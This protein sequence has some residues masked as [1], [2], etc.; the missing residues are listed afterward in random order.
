[1]HSDS[2]NQVDKVSHSVGV[3]L[4]FRLCHCLLL[5]FI[6]KVAMVA[7][8]EVLHGPKNT[9]FQPRQTDLV[10]ATADRLK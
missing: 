4:Y 9:D 5:G 1:M 6:Y 8:V 2:N 7:G 10:T 3:S